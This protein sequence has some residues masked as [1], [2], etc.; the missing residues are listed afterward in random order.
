MLQREKRARGSGEER[1]AG[2][3]DA[4]SQAELGN[5]EMSYVFTR[6]SRPPARA[7]GEPPDGP[8]VRAAVHVSGS[9]GP[10][11][12]LRLAARSEDRYAQ[13]AGGHPAGEPVLPR[14]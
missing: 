7:A 3:R 4:G 12:L 14:A 1:E 5:Q 2:L 9:L 6:Q 11:G 10:L 8:G 13:S